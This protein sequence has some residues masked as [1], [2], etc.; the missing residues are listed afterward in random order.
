M[1]H[2]LKVD[3][4]KKNYLFIQNYANQNKRVEY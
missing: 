4:I 3:E 1:S 2:T